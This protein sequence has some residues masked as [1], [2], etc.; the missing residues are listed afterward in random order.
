MA[1]GPI[2]DD[3]FG[4]VLFCNNNSLNVGLISTGRAIGE[5]LHFTKYKLVTRLIT[6]VI[7]KVISLINII[8]PL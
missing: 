8:T 5:E 7:N 1:K 2:V 3:P 6:K 4:V